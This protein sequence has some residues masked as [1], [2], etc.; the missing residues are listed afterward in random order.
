LGARAI[1]GAPSRPWEPP[2][3]GGRHAERERER[4]REKK[5]VLAAAFLALCAWPAGGQQAPWIEREDLSLD[6]I[7]APTTA[8]RLT[9]A[10]VLIVY[11]HDVTWQ[12]LQKRW[13]LKVDPWTNLEGADGPPLCDPGEPFYAQPTTGDEAPNP[14]VAVSPDGTGMVPDVYLASV[15]FSSDD[16]GQPPFEITNEVRFDHCR[17]KFIDAAV[18]WTFTLGPG[19]ATPPHPLNV[20]PIGPTDIKDVDVIVHLT[21]N[22]GYQDKPYRVSI[23]SPGGPTVVLKDYLDAAQTYYDDE[24]TEPHDPLSILDDYTSLGDWSL[25][26]DRQPGSQGLLTL[27]LQ[28]FEVRL[29]HDDQPLCI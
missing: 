6:G 1:I 16:S 13:R 12:P 23:T 10:E 27:T 18:P 9:Q 3:E 22:L 25:V 19:Q 7:L 26:I 21:G 2:S 4:E 29:H 24:T 15:T 28:R 5:G 17:L 14:T 20:S 11:D 8:E